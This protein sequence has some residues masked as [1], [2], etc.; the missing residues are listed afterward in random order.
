MDNEIKDYVDTRS[1]T[2]FKESTE[3]KWRR[4]RRPSRDPMFGVGF[5]VRGKGRYFVTRR[6]TIN[7]RLCM[8]RTFTRELYACILSTIPPTAMI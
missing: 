5:A 4:H 2:R 8:L 7:E 1:I 6:T 3:D